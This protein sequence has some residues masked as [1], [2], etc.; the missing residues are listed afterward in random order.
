MRWYAGLKKLFFTYS[1]T[2][3]RVQFVLVRESLLQMESAE[4][5]L[6]TLNV[7]IA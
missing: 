6:M 1:Y 5:N 7:K 4:S 3:F 2:S